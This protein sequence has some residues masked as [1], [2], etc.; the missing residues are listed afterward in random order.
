MHVLKLLVNP[1]LNKSPGFICG[2]IL[3]DV[4]VQPIT[5]SKKNDA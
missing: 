1:I 4:V 5:E 3:E 2:V